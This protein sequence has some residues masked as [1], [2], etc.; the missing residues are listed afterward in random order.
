MLLCISIPSA[1]LDG[2]LYIEGSANFI[3][4]SAA[5]IYFK[6]ES[7]LLHPHLLHLF[8]NLKFKF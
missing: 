2:I 3:K 1:M 6:S 8:L 7:D 4:S 5:F